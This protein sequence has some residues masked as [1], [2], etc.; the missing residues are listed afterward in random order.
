M[1][2]KLLCM[3]AAFAAG[4]AS[5]AHAAASLPSYN[6]N[7]SQT[8]VSGLSSGAA[9]A[10]QLGYAYSAT[11]K[12]VGVFAGIPYMCGGHYVYTSCNN[13]TISSSMLSTMQADIN[14][15]SGAAIDNKANVASQKIYMFVGNSDTTV[16][17]KSMNG[18]QTQYTNNGVPTASLDYIKRNSTGHV[19]PTDF[20]ATGNAPCNSSASPYVANCSYD[21][22]KAALTKFY[23]TLNARNDAPAAANYIQFNQSEFTG[24]TGMASTGWVYVPA[25]CAIG[26]VCRVHVALHG[27][28]QYYGAI[29]DKFIKNT[30][31]TR[32]ADTNSIIVLFP[33]TKADSSTHTTPANG[34]ISNPNGCWDAFGWYGTNFAQKAGTQ[35]AAIKAMI[36]RL[37]SGSG[38]HAL[39][40]A[41]ST[42][43]ADTASTGGAGACI[44][45]SNPAHIS[46]GRAYQGGAYAFANGSNQDLGLADT[47]GATSLQETAPN[48]FVTGACQ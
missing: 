37:S 11:F 5:P 29:G 2:L 35:Q 26:A 12:G 32:W 17:P 38:S 44:T 36:D 20:N 46:A 13:A 43:S 15:W 1:N 21:G 10:T 18:V 3:A 25:N 16:G 14:N 30:G 23:G 9:M 41:A 31:F 22:A 34:T 39:A 33:Q 40:A 27:C 28:V 19:F 4:A 24:N 7:T 6:V 8:T 45:A 47:P 48:Y 42:R